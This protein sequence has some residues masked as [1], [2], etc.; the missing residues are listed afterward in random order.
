MDASTVT[1]G[2]TF[3]TSSPPNT[4]WL[5][6]T[7]NSSAANNTQWIVR[8]GVD[9]FGINDKV[10]Q[11][12]A[13]SGDFPQITTRLSGLADGTYTI[14]AFFWDQVDSASQNW[15]I[16]TGLTSGSLTTYSA[17][18]E[19]TIAGAITDNVSN[20]ADLTFTTTPKIQQAYSGSI[21]Q[22]NLFG[23]NLGNVTVAGGSA[24]DVFID[25][26][27]VGTSNWRVWYD[28]LGYQLAGTT[29]PTPTYTPVLGVD[30]NRDD[31]LGSPSQS[32]FRIVSG[33]A[34][35]QAA[36]AASYTKMIGAYQVTVSQPDGTN[37]EFRGA[38]TDSTRAIPGGDT[39]FSYLVSDFIAT[40]KGA[41]DIRITGLA[42]GE[43]QFRSWHLDT[44]TGSTLGFAQGATNTTPNLIEAQVGGLTRAAVQPTALGAPGLNTTFINNSQIPTLDF[45]IT[46]NGGS[47][48]TIR[49]RAIDS[50]GV[51]RFLLLNGF[52]LSQ[53][54]P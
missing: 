44:S 33:S 15:G 40:R 20:A 37:F 9:N 12:I 8:S 38:N 49:L 36:N 13:A 19:P 26:N 11:S 23:V 42:A 17:P 47:P 39:S 1:G 6:T 4:T 35:N 27:L 7:A 45:P 22:Q 28:G 50:N 48:L 46:H 43:Y 21:Y 25:N 24:V 51:D 41:I 30:F 52:E 5:N 2:N 3:L 32:R 14:W 29:P 10:L 31:A 53:P 34:A 54:N 18:G 16:S